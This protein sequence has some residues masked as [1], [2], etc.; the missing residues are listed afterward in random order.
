MR[1][2]GLMIALALCA[3]GCGGSEPERRAEATAEP[4]PAGT[5]PLTVRDLIGRPPR[6]YEIVPQAEDPVLDQLIAALRQGLGEGYRGHDVAVLIERRAPEGTVILVVSFDERSGSGGVVAGAIDAERD[7]D[8][9]GE[10]FEVD[11][12]EGRLVQAVDGSYMASAPAGD[13]GVVMLVARDEPM[14]RQAASV[15]RAPRAR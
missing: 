11:G 9:K 8:L 4:C 14:L 13:C 1:R 5:E 3:A 2:V 15:I 7:H 10:P 6:G 12:R